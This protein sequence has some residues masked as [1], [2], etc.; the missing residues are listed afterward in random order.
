MFDITKDNVKV[1]EFTRLP[2]VPPG[3]EVTV[4]LT[5]AKDSKGARG[6]YAIFE[7]V[8]S[9]VHK[10][11]MQPGDAVKVLMVRLDDPRRV[12]DGTDYS[13]RE[14]VRFLEVV[15]G[16]PFN[17]DTLAQEVDEM[18]KNIRGMAVRINAREEQS[19]DYEGAYTKHRFASVPNQDLK[20]Q[21]KSL[22]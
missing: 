9:Q 10:G 1:S 12:I 7:G 8:V 13:R 19:A 4:L 16:A 5:C 14:V 20:A 6:H 18:C 11:D 21:R 2:L 15:N 22:G 3:N 17:Q